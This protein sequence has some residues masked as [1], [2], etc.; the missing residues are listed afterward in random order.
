MELLRLQGLAASF[1]GVALAAFGRQLL[2]LVFTPDKTGQSSEPP[3]PF[4]MHMVQRENVGL[5]LAL[6]WDIQRRR[7]H[8]ALHR[9]EAVKPF[10]T[11]AVLAHTTEALIDLPNPRKRFNKTNVPPP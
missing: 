8:V 1:L 5:V 2:V 10:V 9:V 11:V 3:L 7:D 6:H 4:D